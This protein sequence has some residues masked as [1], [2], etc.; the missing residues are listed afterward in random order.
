MVARLTTGGELFDL[1]VALE[2]RFRTLGTHLPQ[3]A[4]PVERWAGI[5]F[6]VRERHLLA[7]LDQVAEVLGVPGDITPVP[8]TKSWVVGVANHRGTLLPVFD[9]AA[10]TQG[11]QP[12]RRDTDRILVV[13]Q[14]EL[15]CGLV[16]SAVIGIRHFDV[17]WRVAEPPGGLGVLRPFV[18]ASFPL[19][20][21]PVP[22][23]ALDRLLADPLMSLGSG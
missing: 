17:T 19:E 3:E 5:L 11:G 14:D 13:R 1:I 10:L 12:V 7:P 21:E 18:A 9:L 8:G 15:P 4:A 6:R 20:G 22:V 2:A 23:I 16:A